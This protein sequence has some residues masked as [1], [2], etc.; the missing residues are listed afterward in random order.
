[1]IR[2]P[3]ADIDAVEYDIEQNGIRAVWTT[4][5]FVYP[6]I[7]ETKEKLIASES[8]FGVDRSVYPASIPKSEPSEQERGVFVIEAHSP[9]RAQ[10]ESTL[11]L[12]SNTP[13]VI[14]EHGSLTIIEQRFAPGIAQ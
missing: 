3:G 4:I 5:S 1:M 6:L 14:R 10:V 11:A 13:P 7:F 12:K 2:I 8:I 9:F